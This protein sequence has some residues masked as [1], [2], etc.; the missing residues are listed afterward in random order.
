MSLSILCNMPTIKISARN[1][2]T[3]KGMLQSRLKDR[4]DKNPSKFL[5]SV[6]K[7]KFGI[8]FDDLISELIGN[9]VTR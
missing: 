8:S 7:H 3:L 5:Q 6:V 9:Q 1:Y 2:E 4:M